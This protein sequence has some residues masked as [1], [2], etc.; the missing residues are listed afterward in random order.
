MKTR[1]EF[2]K[3]SGYLAAGAVLAPNLAKAA[4]VSNVGIQLYT[5]RKEM[6]ADAAGTLKQLAKIG[7]KQLESARSDKG[8]FYGLKPKEIKKIASDLGMTVRS[9]HV[10]IDKDWQRSIDMAAEA[11]QSYLV[12]SSLPS[13]GQTVANYQR[14]ADTFSKAAEACKKANL[15]FGYHNHEYEFEKVNGKVLYDI[16]L[17]RTDPKLVKMEMDLGWVIVT[18]NDPL[19]YFKKFP[20]RFPLWHLKDMDKVKK[21]STE[22]GKG[23]INIKTMLQNIDKSGMKFFFVEQEEYPK[24]AMESAK[25]DYDYLAKLTY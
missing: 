25:Y 18:G 21:E 16:L 1:R 5:V 22:F 4:K 9:G 24:T 15:V 3:A 19:A 11:G 14:C 12:C 13:E 10:H 7:Y 17:E 20:G 8:N 6:L 23:Q 2:L